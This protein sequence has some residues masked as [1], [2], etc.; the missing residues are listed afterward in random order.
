MVND[1]QADWFHLDV[2]DGRFVPNITF[3]MFIVEAMAKLA[4]K[5]LDVH[6][7]IV[8]PEK[9]VADFAE[10][11]AD[12]I[13]V[14]AEACPHL[15]RVVQQIRE[16]DKMA[17]VTINPAT[18]LSAIEE[19]LPFVDMVLLMSVNPGF[20]GQKFIDTTLARIER[21]RAML[22]ERALS[23]DIEVDGGIGPGNIARVAAAGANIFVAGSAIF[24]TDDYKQTIDSMR[25][26]LE[27]V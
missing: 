8:E 27:G 12:I 10:A 23:V 19:I 3:G 16:L 13:T 20:G 21:L 24:G 4:K 7:M 9:Y 15:H 25:A 18:P 1:S 14:H 17:G 5:P 2:M 6:L 11:G 22:D 26:A